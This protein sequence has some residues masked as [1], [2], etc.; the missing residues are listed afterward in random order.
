MATRAAPQR[1]AD[2]GAASPSSDVQSFPNNVGK[3]ALAQRQSVM[4]K[5][6]FWLSAWYAC[7][8][9][10]LFLNKII[11][12]QFGGD[13]EVLGGCQM[14]MTAFLG[15]IKVYGSKLL[16]R[17]QTGTAPPNVEAER[18][19]Y[20]AFR[21]NML[22]VAIMR[23]STILLGLVSLAN[24]AASFTETIK[25][26]SPFFTVI[27]THLILRETTSVRPAP[28]HALLSDRMF[29]TRSSAAGSGLTC[30]GAQVQ[31]NLSLIP[32]MLGLV[33]CRCRPPPRLPL[34]CLAH[35]SHRACVSAGARCAE[36]LRC[37]QRYGAVVQ[38]HRVLRGHHHELHRLRAERLLQEA[39]HRWPLARRAAV[40]H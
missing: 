1:R 7:S 22:L 39:A 15:A 10:T 34:S 5:T 33:V 18:E 8:G 26:S 4:M 23:S 24:V 17:G 29:V 30:L 36:R 37:L 9:G 12:T 31:V 16:N 2:L 28:R 40:L 35:L 38:P 6:L 21:R 11:L 27:F 14:A 32:V 25:A 3:L 13:V 19:S 20:A